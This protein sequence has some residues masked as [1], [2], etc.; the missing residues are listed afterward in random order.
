MKVPLSWLNDYVDVTV[1]IPELADRL[2]FAGLE[3]EQMEYVGVPRPKASHAADERPELAWDRDK[4][5]VGKI[6]EVKPHPNADRLTLAVVEIARG[7]PIQVVTGAPNIRIGD[8]GQKVAFALEGAILFDGHKEGWELMTLKRAKIRGVESGCMVCSEKELGLSEDHEGII[9]LPEDAPV[10]K[11][12]VDYLGEV[13]FEI[14]INP[15]MAR[16]ASI[17]GIAREVA[18]LTG[19]KIKMPPLDAVQ[20]GASI[21][22]QVEV[23]I[24]EPELNPRFTAALIRGIVIQPSPFWV[25]RRLKLAGMRPINNIVDVTNYVMLEIGQPLHAFDYDA[26]VRRSGKRTPTIITRLADPGEELDTLDGVKR[27]LDSFNILVCDTKGALSLGGIMGGAESE[28]NDHSKNILLEA[29]A[30]NYLNIRRTMTAQHLA[31]EAG[32]RFG[33]GVHPSQA[34][35]GLQRAIEMMRELAKGEIAKGFIDVYPLKPKQARIKLPIGEVKRQLGVDIPSKQAIKILESLE[36]Q[37]LTEEPKA[38]SSRPSSV[39]GHAALVVIPPDYRLDVDGTDDLIEEIARLY[40]YDMIPMS[41]MD[42][43]LPPQRANVE[44]EQE[45]FAR[46]LLIRYGLQEVIGYRF[47]TPEREA[48]LTL[49]GSSRPGIPPREYVRIE[50]PISADRSALR[51][52][53]LPNLLELAASNLRYRPRVAVFE[54]GPVFWHRGLEDVLLPYEI[55]TQIPEDTGLKLPLERRRLGILLTGSRDEIHWEKADTALMDFFDLKGST[56]ALLD[57]LHV[58]EAKFVVSDH[59]SLHPRRAASLQIDGQEIGFLGEIHPLLLERFDL[60]SQAVLVSELDLDALL[61][62]ASAMY[63]VRA[64]TRYPGVVQDLAL[65]V[66]ESIAAER[67]HALIQ[68]TGGALL[69]R[70][71]LFDIYRG[72]Q[73]ARGKK[74]LAYQLTFQAVDRTLSDAD[75]SKVR[76]KIVARLQKEVGAEVRGQ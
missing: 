16:C 34:I 24:L 70:A 32:T 30:W 54:I 61:A 10:G 45:E 14:K 75:A 19:K 63:A 59:P 20:K 41:R 60:P 23:R 35:V 2:T 56:Q 44:L 53:L 22:G 29:A 9:L 64:P 48:K 47:T 7:E 13:I 52:T 6:L 55:R 62:H 69:Q 68:E 49:P 40:G 42:D 1:S 38:M 39:S 37:V 67:I 46:D 43:E 73:I 17:I 15:N 72:E 57:D 26:L 4:L 25:Q 28:I 33:R 74:S 76:E 71:V 36:F 12:L 21:E 3:V 65:V 51:Q 27:K 66:D 5:V 58:S 31:S 18:A 11:P 8:I 50:N